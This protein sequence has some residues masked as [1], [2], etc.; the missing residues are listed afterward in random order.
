MVFWETM[1]SRFNELVR[2][3]RSN[4]NFANR[5]QVTYDRIFRRDLALTHYIWKNQFVFVCSSR[6]GDHRA[7]QECFCERVYDA[8]LDRC[9]IAGNKITYVNIGA[10]IGAFDVLLAERGLTIEAGLAA[11]LN[12][13]TFAKCVVN[14]QANGFRQTKVVNGGIGE[15]DGR[16]LFNPSGLTLGD[17][18]FAP[19]QTSTDGAVE[20]E[21]FT[22]RT[23]LERHAGHFPRFDLLK[24][25]CTQAEYA[26][27]RSSPAE[28]LRKFRYIIVE[29]HPV[30][31]GES[32]EAAYSRLKEIGFSPWLDRRSDTDFVDLFTRS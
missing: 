5:F 1:A 24:L 16:L 23:L 19:A 29:F 32:I 22:L 26:I 21:Q 27:I 28:L 3:F 25:D 6:L 7:I 10:H 15:K 18:I 20:V 2:G 13:Q 4:F 17:G 12:P 11:E 30:P 9:D 8:Y 14:L 31:E